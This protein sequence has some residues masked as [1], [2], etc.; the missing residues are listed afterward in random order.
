MPPI[1]SAWYRTDKR[2][3]ANRRD[4]CPI[5]P[6]ERRELIVGY[7]RVRGAVHIGPYTIRHVWGP[8]A[9]QTTIGMEIFRR[10]ITTFDA[11]RGV[12]H[13]VPNRTL[14]E[15]VPEPNA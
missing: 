1:G 14:I 13:L 7:P 12:L 6:G 10:F 9:P 3:N 8:G 4:D 5:T 15:P 2:R 11:Q